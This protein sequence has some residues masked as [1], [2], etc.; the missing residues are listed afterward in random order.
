L[1]NHPAAPAEWRNNAPRPQTPTHR[2]HVTLPPMITGLGHQATRTF[3]A[4]AFTF[5]VKTTHADDRDLVQSLFSDLP[6]PELDLPADGLFVLTRHDKRSHPVRW[7]LVGPRVPEEQP[8]DLATVLTR[9]LGAVNLCALDSDPEGLHLHAAAAVRDGRTVV[10]AA[11]RNTGKTTTIAHLCRRG[12]SFVTDETVRLSADGHTVSGFAKPLSIKP[13]GHLHVEHLQPLLVPHDG[14]PAESFRF[15]AIGS[16]GVSIAA[17]GR[18]HT[19]IL[20]RRDLEDLH[21]GPAAEALHTSDAVVALM[22]ETLDAERFG[23]TALCLA[24]FAGNSRCFVVTLGSPDET[25]DNIAELASLEPMKSAPV[26]ALPPSDAIQS[27]VRSVLVD[28]RAVVHEQGSGRIFALDEPATRIW[29][30]LG[31]WQRDAAINFNGP[32]LAPFVR[33]LEALGVLTAG[34]VG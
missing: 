18:P 30:H 22:Q 29:L 14:D 16:S 6:A 12:W 32:G 17:E 7:T 31:G 25:A 20:L 2:E 15:A 19:V 9:L 3:R 24:R 27:S 21:R 1:W 8:S 5:L 11:Q 13:N 34:A 26:S 10:I 33:Q 4:G 28:G 23:A